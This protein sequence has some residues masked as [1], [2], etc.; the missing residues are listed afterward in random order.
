MMDGARSSRTPSSTAL[1]CLDRGIIA[2][3]ALFALMAPHSIA[4]TQGAFLLGLVLWMVRIGIR[5]SLDYRPMALDLPILAFV[6]WSLLA[7]IFSYEPALSLLKV[8][9]V[10]LFLI[11]F[12]VAQN[13][14]NREWGKRW[15]LILVLSCFVNVGY[16]F[17]QKSVGRGLQLVEID[18]ASPLHHAG[19]RSGDV[20]LSVEGRTIR[21]LEELAAKAV[22]KRGERLRLFVFRPEIYMHREVIVPRGAPPENPLLIR[23]AEPWKNFRASGFYGWNYFTY[24]E[25]VQ[26][27]A[28]LLLGLYLT[29]SK[30][31]SPWGALALLGIGAMTYA[32]LLTVT[33]AVWGAFA[34]S[35]FVMMVHR[36]GKKAVVVAV[37]A[38]LI[39]APVGA[40]FLQQVRSI[41]LLSAR[42]PST[43]YRLTV[44]REGVQLLF[45][46][47]KHWLLGIGMDSLKA[48]WR[49]WGMF[50][51]GRLPLGHMHSSPLQIALERGLPALLCWFWWFARYLQ[52]LRRGL[53]SEAVNRDPTIAG[54]YLGT[55]GGTLGFLA[56]SLVHYN[57]GDSEVI[58]IVYFQMGLIEGF[59]RLLRDEVRG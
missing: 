41:P 20:L 8:R 38:L 50:Q 42:E 53:R 4:A 21:S 40:R 46:H 58:M 54:I 12:L 19:I 14:P 52:L 7:A 27:L 56:S 16:V 1:A 49:E 5:R 2:S 28:S 18:E 43:A 11:V 13:L 39:A 23:R 24:A 9:S 48:R 37:L 6:W 33:R 15:A 31:R 32:I 25:V 44:W 3:V 45:R 51:G 30:K 26:L 17:W 55:L 22:A 59:H 29:S 57:F 36:W 34:L 35:A 10:G 47:P